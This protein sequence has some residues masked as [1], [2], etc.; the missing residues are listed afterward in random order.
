[1]HREN[2]GKILATK[3]RRKGEGEVILR[4][5]KLFCIGCEK[6]EKLQIV[7]LTDQQ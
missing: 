2:F 6:L 5:I 4:D 7:Q 3:K 1:M